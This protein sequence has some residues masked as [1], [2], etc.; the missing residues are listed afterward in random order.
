MY[1]GPDGRLLP[2]PAI[3]TTDLN[4]KHSKMAM[5]QMAFF[6]S[7]PPCSFTATSVIAMKTTSVSVSEP[8]IQPRLPLFSGLCSGGRNV[9]AS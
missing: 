2:W 1:L 8:K 9:N 7:K 6:M 4:V 3:V 5:K